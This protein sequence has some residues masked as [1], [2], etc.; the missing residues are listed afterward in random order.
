MDAALQQATAEASSPAGLA[1][2]SAEHLD[3]EDASDSEDSG[4]D[5][6]MPADEADETRTFTSAQV[7]GIVA[8]RLKRSREAAKSRKCGA[9]VRT[10][11]FAK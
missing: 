2:G 11:A 1:E 6:S 3:F 5:M 10:A 8:Q 9:K 7:K 4:D